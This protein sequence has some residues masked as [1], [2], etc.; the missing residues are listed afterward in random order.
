MTGLLAAANYT[1]TMKLNPNHVYVARNPCLGKSIVKLGCTSNPIGREKS[2]S[3][4][5][6]PDKYKLV[7]VAYVGD[8]MGRAVERRM[9]EHFAS[10]R[11]KKEFYHI[12]NIDDVRTVIKSCGGIIYDPHV[13]DIYDPH[14]EDIDDIVNDDDDDK[15]G[16]GWSDN[17][18]NGLIGHRV[19][20]YH[21]RFGW[22]NGVVIAGADGLFQVRYGTRDDDWVSIATLRRILV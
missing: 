9:H 12:E 15:K 2:L 17:D 18:D 20:R 11:I 22:A 7:M 5:S 14:V 10:R 16:A 3:N 4:S 6:V 8:N 19:R 21:G 13:E 1:K